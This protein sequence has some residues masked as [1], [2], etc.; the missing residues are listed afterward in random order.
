MPGLKIRQGIYYLYWRSKLQRQ[1][2]FT[3]KKSIIN[4][5][6][7]ALGETLQL[8]SSF[9]EKEMNTVPFEGSWTAA[10]VCRHL[11]KS[12]KGMDELFYAPAK[13]ADRNPAERAEN[14]KELFLN[15]DTKMKSPDFIAPEDKHYEK[16]E[17]EGSLEEAKDKMLEAAQNV[18][19]AEMAALP[20]EHPLKGS[21]KLEMIY[22]V[23]YHTMRHNHQLKKIREKI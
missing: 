22:F 4:Q 15:F 10:Q 3:W 1:F 14:F 9:D 11:Y 21:T 16:K 8:L 5:L 7:A 19:L 12:E 23:T 6:E 17:L 13:P 20:D 18:N 2:T